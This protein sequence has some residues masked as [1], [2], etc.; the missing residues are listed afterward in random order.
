MWARSKCVIHLLTSFLAGIGQLVF[1]VAKWTWAVKTL[2]FSSLSCF[3]LNTTL[4]T[5]FSF[6]A[7]RGAYFKADWAIPYSVVFKAKAQ[8]LCKEMNN[9]VKG[10]KVNSGGLLGN[11]RCSVCEVSAVTR[12]VCEIGNRPLVNQ[13]LK[14]SCCKMFIIFKA[15]Y[16]SM[17]LLLVL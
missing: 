11:W 2:G 5:A 9:V 17:V 12:G 13:S 16:F 7:I 3:P 4:P 8:V 10:M 15:S 6:Q 14:W 1:Y